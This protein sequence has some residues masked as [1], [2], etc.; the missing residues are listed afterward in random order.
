MAKYVGHMSGD[1]PYGELPKVSDR[2][3]VGMKSKRGYEI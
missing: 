3:A 1:I 2:P